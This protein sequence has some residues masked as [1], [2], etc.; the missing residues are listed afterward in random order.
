MPSGHLLLL[1][2]VPRY[3]VRHH[4]AEGRIAAMID[5]LTGGLALDVGYEGSVLRGQLRC[6]VLVVAHLMRH[7]LTVDGELHASLIKPLGLPKHLGGAKEV[8]LLAPCSE[9]YRG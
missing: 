1:R 2:R 7:C 5:E 6:D 8:T 9:L 3:R 4:R